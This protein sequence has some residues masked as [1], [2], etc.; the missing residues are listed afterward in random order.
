MANSATTEV[1]TKTCPECAAIHGLEIYLKKITS[2]SSS[3]KSYTDSNGNSNSV[4]LSVEMVIYQCP[5]CKA[6]FDKDIHTTHSSGAKSTYS[7][8]ME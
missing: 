5:C 7:N 3:S 6:I 4:E 2:T 1:S 8:L